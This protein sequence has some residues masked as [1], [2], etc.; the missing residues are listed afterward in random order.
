MDGG[1]GLS[2]LA[3][4][5]SVSKLFFFFFSSSSSSSGGLIP[6]SR[7]QRS[8]APVPFLC[9][10]LCHRMLPLSPGVQACCWLVSPSLVCARSWHEN[11]SPGGRSG[12]VSIF[13]PLGELISGLLRQIPVINDA[14]D[15]PRI[16]FWRVTNFAYLTM[17]ESVPVV[18]AAANQINQSEIYFTVIR[19]W[20]C[21]HS[22]NYSCNINNYIH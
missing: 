4:E 8:A 14:K 20:C 2:M 22:P 18:S 1:P 19:Y 9:S 3:F 7:V 5:P 15:S 6:V 12:N 10:S 17:E 13:G 16:I 11:F 21:S